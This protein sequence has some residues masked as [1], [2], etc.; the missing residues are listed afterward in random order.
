MIDKHKLKQLIDK[1]PEN[2]SDYFDLDA[3]EVLPNLIKQLFNFMNSAYSYQ[4]LDSI[5]R[6]DMEFE[7]LF[8]LLKL[9][10]A[11]ESQSQWFDQNE[12][13]LSTEQINETSRVLYSKQQQRINDL[14]ANT[15]ELESKI[16]DLKAQITTLNQLIDQENSSK[17]RYDQLIKEESA[18]RNTKSSLDAL[19]QR[20]EDGALIKL[21]KDIKELEQ[22]LEPARKKE[23]SLRE[24]LQ[25][26]FNQQRNLEDQCNQHIKETQ[27]VVVNNDLLESI[28]EQLEKQN[29]KSSELLGAAAEKLKIRLKF[30]QETAPDLISNALGRQYKQL[31]EEIIKLEAGIKATIK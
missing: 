15:K 1:L 20:V 13:I 12:S 10:Q 19:K 30:N 8:F 14:S 11:F 25:E 28:T 2:S 9:A 4:Q 7:Y 21:E 16:T 5:Q 26:V 24:K 23:Q 18:L 27:R 22:E 17:Q 3:V 31:E 6:Q 29:M